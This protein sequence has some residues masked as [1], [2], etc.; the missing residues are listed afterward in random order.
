MAA[1]SLEKMMIW[2]EEEGAPLLGINY[3]AKR[4]KWRYVYA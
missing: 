4:M 1:A 3:E 2:T